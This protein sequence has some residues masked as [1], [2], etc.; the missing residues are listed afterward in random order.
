MGRYS[1]DLLLNDTRGRVVLVENQ[2]EQTDHVHLGQVLTYCAGTQAEVVIWIAQ[3]ITEEHAAALE[4]LN[5]NTVSGIEFF[6]V[7]VEV[8]R[9]GG[10]APAP[11]FRVVVKPNTYTKGS[12][13]SRARVTT[14]T[15]EAYVEEL[16]VPAARAEVGRLLLDAVVNEIEERGLAWQPVMNKGYVAIQRSGGYNALVIDVYWNKAPRLA[17]KLPASPD[18]L[19]LANPYPHLQQIWTPAEREW[20]WTIPP[21][22]EPPDLRPLFDLVLPFQPTS[23]PMPALRNSF[24]RERK[25]E[26]G[27]RRGGE[28]GQTRTLGRV[29][30]WASTR[31]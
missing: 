31:L 16:R 9:I 4:W 19:G 10:S 22:T 23:G 8:L 17:A 12:H 27:L 14:W 28:Y 7:E 11:N 30:S 25:P 29:R 1:L 15:W 5:S 2:L 6:G 18:E 20:G 3:S 13:G 21:G 24:L 26:T